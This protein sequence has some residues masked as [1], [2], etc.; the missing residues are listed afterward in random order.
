MTTGRYYIRGS[1]KTKKIERLLHRAVWSDLYGPIPKGMDVHHK[2]ED[3]TD[4]RPENLELMDHGKH[5]SMH[6]K[7]KSS[8]PEYRKKMISWL[9]S[10]R[11][12]GRKWHRSEEGRRQHG[13]T[14]KKVWKN[15]LQ[16]RS[17]FTCLQ[18]GKTF[19]GYTKRPGKF[20]S[21]PCWRRSAYLRGDRNEDRTCIECGNVWSTSKFH[22]SKTC[23]IKCQM[24]HRRRSMEPSISTR[25]KTQE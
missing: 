18:C 5:M 15:L 9:E 10:G 7:K 11:E 14:L 3:W 21:L 6:G 25:Q 2:N 20:C 17:E 24:L 16:K 1:R 4:N 12:S 19:E 22:T 13:E 8:D 23:S